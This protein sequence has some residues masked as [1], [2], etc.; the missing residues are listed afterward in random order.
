MEKLGYL[1]NS[2]NKV[3]YFITELGKLVVQSGGF[4]EFNK[5]KSK[6]REFEIIAKTFEEIAKIHADTQSNNTLVKY[7]S[8]VTGVAIV[9][10]ALFTTLLYFTEPLKQPLETLITKQT[11]LNDSLSHQS[12]RFQTEIDSLKMELHRQSTKIYLKPDTIKG[13]KN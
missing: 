4:D 10:Q 6:S 12:T 2:G 9:V 3:L 8:I 5:K 13:R 11:E 7:V 1:N